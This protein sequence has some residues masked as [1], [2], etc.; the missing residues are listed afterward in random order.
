MS[1]SVIIREG[2]TAMAFTTVR[3]WLA[4]SYWTPGI[5]REVIERASRN[6]ALV[7]GAFSEDGA[8]AGFMR[9]VSD[10][11]R[12]AYLCDVIVADEWRGRGVA[13]RMVRH[14]L[15]H[16]ELM[17]VRTWTLATRDAHGVYEPLG[18]KPMSHPESRAET[19]MVLRRGQ[20]WADE[21]APPSGSSAP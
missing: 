5:E 12:F 11:V 9:V 14:A 18:F 6:S 19:W 17:T 10:K 1:D 16:P 4:R 20:S 21:S 8:Q 2:I 7:I 15:D 3:E 13:R